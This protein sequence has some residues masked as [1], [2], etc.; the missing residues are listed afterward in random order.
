MSAAG[1]LEGA[2][3]H[4]V[5]RDVLVVDGDLWMIKQLR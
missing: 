5:R 2:V 3:K 1:S 4:F